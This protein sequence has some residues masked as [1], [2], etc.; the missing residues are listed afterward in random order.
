MRQ[1]A[2]VKALEAAMALLHSQVKGRPKEADEVAKIL[3]QTSTLRSNEMPRG[4]RAWCPSLSLNITGWPL[5]P[6]PLSLVSCINR[7]YTLKQMTWDS[8]MRDQ[9]ASIAAAGVWWSAKHD[10]TVPVTVVTQATVDRL[11]QL[12]FQCKSWLGPLS[13]VLYLGLHQ[14]WVEGSSEPPT[15]TAENKDTLARA[16]ASVADLFMDIEKDPHA[17]KLDVMLVYEVYAEERAMMLFPINALRNMARLQARTPLLALI[18]VDMLVSSSLYKELK[19]NSVFLKQ[20]LDETGGRISEPGGIFVLPAFEP[21]GGDNQEQTAAIA[22]LLASKDKRFLIS[23]GIGKKL[24]TPFDAQ[25][26]PQGHN[27]TLFSKWY[28][29]SS[30]DPYVVQYGHRYEPW[31]IVDAMKAPWHDA[32]FRGYGNNKIVHVAHMNSSGFRFN[33]LPQSFIVHRSHAQ[34]TARLGLIASK[35]LYD[36][37]AASEGSS[38]QSGL[39][40]SSSVYGHTKELFDQAVARMAANDYQPVLDEPTQACK[41]VLPWLAKLS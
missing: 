27:W 11:P 20:L 15:L 28:T 37:A 8:A 6:N 24:A 17:C 1:E 32:R 5:E 33:V 7:N 16:S 25:R 26:F 19:T 10:Q 29:L 38:V 13:A 35:T 3:S 2:R 36:T 18:D 34:T 21:V 4:T 23:Y 14:P 22:D 30:P 41:S 40:L 9:L 12:Y 39:D 31:T